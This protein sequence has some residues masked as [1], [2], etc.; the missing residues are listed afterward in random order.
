MGDS[1]GLLLLLQ[2][3]LIALN[4]VFA[5]A[6]IA[7]ISVNDTK[8]ERLA[9]EGDTRAKRLL[10]LTQEPAKFLATIQVA[11]TLSGFL[12]SAFAADNFSGPLVDWLVSLGVTIPRSTLSTI[13]VIVITLVLSYFT[14]IF[15]ELVPKRIAMKKS[16]QLSMKI[17]GLVSAISVA[18]KPIVWFLS[19]S[20]NLVLRLCGIDPTEAEDEVSEEEI[21][22][23]V[24]AGSEKGII[25]YQEK[26]FIQNVFEFDD[27]NAGDIATHRTDV[28][29]LWMDDD[30]DAWAETIHDTRHTRYPVCDGSPDHVIGI[31]NAKDYFRLEDKTKENIFATAVRPAY[32]VPETIKADVLF[33]NMK[34]TRHV[35]AVVMDEY[36]GMVG[37]V[38]LY[39]LV[40]ELVGELNDEPDEFQAPEP[41][42]E[43]TGENTWSVIGNVELSDVEEALGIEI[44]T[45]ED[46]DTFTGLVFDEL[47]MIPNEG[48]QNIDLEIRNMKIHVSSIAEHQIEAAT[49][50]LK[51][52]SKE[53]DPEKKEV[54]KEVKGAE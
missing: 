21:R 22:M 29:I 31:L 48:A 16:E 20:T 53:A 7:V 50:I 18:F 36:G 15:G 5:S 13:A 39:D 34:K 41:H 42:I 27:I 11:I 14:L 51:E 9:E 3:V 44:E 45:E 26:E 33:R 17:S 12:G 43:K 19:V 6:E 23:L 2:V 10:K 54:R 1:I 8:M 24:D 30:L 46:I 28:D 25:A 52:E 37:V 40:E 38:T 4:A 49:I 32:F 47:G 35:M